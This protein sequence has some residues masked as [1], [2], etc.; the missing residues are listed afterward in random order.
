VKRPKT[1][2]AVATVQRRQILDRLME[3]GVTILDPA[4]TYIED[5]VTIVRTRRSI[6]RW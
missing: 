6:P 1:A 3:G 4:S 2:P 5:A